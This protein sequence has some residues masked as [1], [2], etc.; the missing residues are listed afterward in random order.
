[1]VYS[2]M[3]STLAPHIARLQRQRKHVRVTLS[4]PCARTTWR[5]RCADAVSGKHCAPTDAPAIL[6][7]KAV[8]YGRQ[9]S[10]G[11]MRFGVLN[12]A[13]KLFG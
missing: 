5:P 10:F 11:G 2:K 8:I 7:S 1:M 13:L 4:V 6:F 9:P 12:E 3:L